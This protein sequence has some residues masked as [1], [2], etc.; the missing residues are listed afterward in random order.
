MSGPCAEVRN[1]AGS[2]EPDSRGSATLELVIL[3]PALLALLG[4]VIVAGRIT[5]AGSAVE[6]A[7]SAGARAASLERDARAAR[8]AAERSVRQSLTEQSI[9]C[10]PLSYDIDVT[11]F[12][13]AVGRP[14]STSVAIT[15]AVPIGDLAVPGMPGSRVVHAAATSPLDRYRSRS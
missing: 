7:A 9:K 6:Q 14:A 11:G 2:R 10:L 8:A 12:T 13:V 4:L 15:C 3:A 5:A 1:R